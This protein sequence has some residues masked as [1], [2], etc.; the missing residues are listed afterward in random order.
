MILLKDLNTRKSSKM[1]IFSCDLGN[2]RALEII[3]QAS[4][5]MGIFTCDCQLNVVSHLQLATV[6]HCNVVE[7]LAMCH[8]GHQS[9]FCDW[10]PTHVDGNQLVAITRKSDYSI[11]CNSWAVCYVDGNQ[12]VAISRHISYSMCYSDQCSSH[13]AGG[14]CLALKLS[15]CTSH[16]KKSSTKHPRRWGYSLATASR[17]AAICKWWRS[18]TPM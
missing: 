8:Q 10:A 4:S 13:G 18:C 2:R 16:F 12:L 5:K 15:F 9:S 6:M 14:E 1:G 3:N 11:I 17:M 7:L